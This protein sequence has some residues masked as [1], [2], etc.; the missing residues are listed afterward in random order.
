MTNNKNKPN[1]K[2]IQSFEDYEN[3]NGLEIHQN[4]NDF[5]VS[6]NSNKHFHHY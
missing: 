6:L 2:T 5:Q 3:G 4:F 1:E